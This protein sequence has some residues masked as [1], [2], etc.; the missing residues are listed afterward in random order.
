MNMAVKSQ[1]FE[2]LA[3]LSLNKTQ[4]IES[5]DDGDLILEGVASTTSQDLEGDI[6]TPEAIA[7]MKKQALQCNIRL[8]HWNG[9][10]GDFIDVVVGKVI[11]VLDSSKNELKVKF[12]ILKSYAAKIK[13]YI[14]AGINL[15]LSIGAKINKYER[16][17][18][19]E[20]RTSFL[21]ILD[22]LLIEITLTS[23]PVNW[24]TY[25]TVTTNKGLIKSNCF[26]GACYEI[27]KNSDEVDIMTN[28]NNENNEKNLSDSDLEKIKNMLN[29]GL[30][31]QTDVIANKVQ[32]ELEPKLK[33]IV[34]EVIAENNNTNDGNNGKSQNNNQ[35]DNQDN[36][37]NNDEYGGG[38]DSEKTIKTITENV[39]KEV[40]ANLLEDLNKNR[41]PQGSDINGDDNGGENNDTNKSQPDHLGLIPESPEDIAKTY[42][43]D[44]KN[45]IQ[46]IFNL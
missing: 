20:S 9:P 17:T 21:K 41:Q 32:T 26:A 46:K 4:T 25:G 22:V 37:S 5:N 1:K 38:L 30:N 11:E 24:D 18:N 2:V 23:L 33:S 45:P 40:T 42:N 28:E 36:N 29:E 14:D 35:G 10:N 15:G 43:P 6:I 34:N 44:S 8:S 16:I 31:A 27:Y 13:E 19:D 39:A 3:P 12:K 7:S